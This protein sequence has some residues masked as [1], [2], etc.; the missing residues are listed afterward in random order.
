MDVRACLAICRRFPDE[1]HT[2]RMLADLAVV[3]PERLDA[4]GVAI[5]RSL[6]EAT[7]ALYR[8]TSKSKSHWADSVTLVRTCVR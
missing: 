7:I 2:A 1:V 5:P 4:L 8:S 3:T 6:A